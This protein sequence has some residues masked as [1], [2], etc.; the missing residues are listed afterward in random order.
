MG[1]SGIICFPTF[2]ADSQKLKIK[3]VHFLLFLTKGELGAF[4]QII[5][6]PHL[7]NRQQGSTVTSS[8]I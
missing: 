8:R 5:F 4:G 3:L 7:P 2:E 1:I 6:L